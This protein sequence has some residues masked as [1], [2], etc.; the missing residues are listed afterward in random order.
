MC[1]FL[2]SYMHK[3]VHIP[4][5][6]KEAN[7]GS[8][9]QKSLARIH[10]L[11]KCLLQSS[12]LYTHHTRAQPFGSPEAM[13]D[14]VAFV[15]LT[16]SG[17]NVFRSEENFSMSCPKCKRKASLRSSVKSFAIASNRTSSR[18]NLLQ[19][20]V[21]FR[22]VEAISKCT[23]WGVLVSLGSMTTFASAL[24]GRKI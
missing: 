7:V 1:T 20:T 21:S 2:I 16:N 22:R 24:C 3:C 15:L 9:I 8:I 10:K 5:F 17:S 12:I 14:W 19:S 11:L 23:L 18:S 6:K 4:I 13:L